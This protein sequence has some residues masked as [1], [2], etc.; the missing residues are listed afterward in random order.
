[1]KLDYL[2]LNLIKKTVKNIRT[3]KCCF[4]SIKNVEILFALMINVMKNCYRAFLALNYLTYGRGNLR[5]LKHHQCATS[6][7]YC[8]DGVGTKQRENPHASTTS[9]KQTGNLT[10]T[11]NSWEQLQTNNQQQTT[12]EAQRFKYTGKPAKQENKGLGLISNT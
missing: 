2:S 8:N 9:I 3:S 11:W 7:H 12:T 6:K 5:V 1:M 10:R 4:V